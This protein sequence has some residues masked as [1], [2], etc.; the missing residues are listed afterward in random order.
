MIVEREGGRREMRD[1]R[2]FADRHA[3]PGWMRAI[4]PRKGRRGIG[5]S[6]IWRRSAGIV[7]AR[8]M[9]VAIS[10][11]RH[12]AALYTDNRIDLTEALGIR[13]GAQIGAI[14]GHDTSI[15]LD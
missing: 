15:G 10:R 12:G 6:P 7:D 4:H 11:A 13:D 5:C 14:D 9:Y 8:W 1:L 3:R 2:Y